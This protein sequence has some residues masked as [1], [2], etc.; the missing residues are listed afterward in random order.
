MCKLSTLVLGEIT[1]YQTVV[2][3]RCDMFLG[4]ALCNMLQGLLWPGTEIEKKIH[5]HPLLTAV[6][7][8]EVH[9]TSSQRAFFDPT[10][11][12]FVTDY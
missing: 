6:V 4:P 3:N 10:E 7:V 12:E 11:I 9:S 5:S 2:P 1:I 8:L